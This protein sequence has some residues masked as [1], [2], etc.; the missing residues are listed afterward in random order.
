MSHLITYLQLGTAILLIL[1]VVLQRSGGDIGGA[2][3]GDGAQFSRTR[4]GFEKFL[5]FATI[6]VGAVFV[7]ASIA[8]FILK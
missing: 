5:F 2:F 4:R 6:A 3:G 1:L 8:T 7:L